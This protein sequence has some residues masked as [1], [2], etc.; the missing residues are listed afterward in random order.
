MSK[1][2]EQEE[3]IK[4]VEGYIDDKRRVFVVTK[5]DYGII[6]KKIPYLTE[7]QEVKNHQHVRE[8]LAKYKPEN[9]K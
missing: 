9:Y 6:S 5:D 2:L 7:E 1:R 8:L 3:V 4:K